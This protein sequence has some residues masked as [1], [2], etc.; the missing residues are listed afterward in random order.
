M[1]LLKLSKNNEAIYTLNK[2]R[3]TIP[4]A[5]IAGGAIR[6]LYHDKHIKDI[7]IFVPDD[8]SLT[9]VDVYSSDFWKR[10]FD[11]TTSIYAN[12]YV[13][14][15]GDGDDGSCTEKEDINMVWEILKNGTL[16][17]VIIVNMDPTEYVTRFFDVGLCKAYCDGS[18]IKLTSDFMH[19]SRFKRLTLV[20]E[21]MTLDEFYYMMDNHIVN[22]KQKYPN[23]SLV[24]PPRYEE[25]YK[26]YNEK[27]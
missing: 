14:T 21:R 10:Q 6:D 19:D 20:S 12:N 15:V 2:I 16:Y 3:E 24:V 25:Y 23:H 1:N 18:R 27:A 26:D 9:G 5:I 13:K 8:T 11:L 4:S 22:L 7:D 17:N